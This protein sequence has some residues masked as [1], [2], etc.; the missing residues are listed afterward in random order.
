MYEISMQGAVIN[1]VLLTLKQNKIHYKSF[2]FFFFF[3]KKF[4]KN[5]PKIFVAIYQRL[6]T[7]KLANFYEQK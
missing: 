1:S 3:F 4:Y 5:I 7:Y 6:C 2:F